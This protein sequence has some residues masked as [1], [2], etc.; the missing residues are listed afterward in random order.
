MIQTGFPSLEDVKQRVIAA[1]VNLYRYDREL[2]EINANER[3]I[4]HKLAEYLQR[5]FPNW[6]VDCEYNRRWDPENDEVVVK[7]MNVEFDRINPEDK[8]AKTVYPDIIVHQR[9]TKINLLVIEVK[10]EG[11]TE[12]TQDKE[13]LRSFGNDPLYAYC[14]GIFLRLG[15]SGCVEA[16]IFENSRAEIQ[17]TSYVQDRLKELVYGG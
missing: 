17:W 3:S 14:Y 13:K 4:T 11:G 9:R 7:T 8:E 12:N 16:L 2:L 15:S 6:N 5:E 10:K 1:V